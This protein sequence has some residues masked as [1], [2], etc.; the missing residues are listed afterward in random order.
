MSIRLRGDIGFYKNM[1]T[2]LFISNPLAFIPD[3]V[4]KGWWGGEKFIS[5]NIAHQIILG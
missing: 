3:E 5:V 4:P 2:F 1:H